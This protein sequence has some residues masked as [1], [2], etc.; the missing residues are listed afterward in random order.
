MLLRN[1]HSMTSVLVH[2]GLICQE[3]AESEVIS[4]ELGVWHLGA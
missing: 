4:W 2:V 3:V 1:S